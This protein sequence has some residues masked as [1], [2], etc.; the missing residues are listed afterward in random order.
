MKIA[1]ILAREILDSRGN[2]TVEVALT[3]E[4][5]W[6]LNAEGVGRTATAVLGRASVPSG[7]STGAHEA[8]ELRDDEARYGGLGVTRAVGNVNNEIKNTLLGNEYDQSTLDETLIRLDGTPNKSRLGANAILG[9]SLA[10]AHAQAKAFKYLY[11]YFAD[12][13]D[14]ETISLPLPLMNVLNGGKQATNSLDFQEYMIVPVG[15][16]SFHEALRYGAETFHALKKILEQKNLSTLVGDEGGFAPTLNSNEEGI[17]L[18]ME[19][20]DKAGYSA[21]QDIAIAIDSAASGWLSGDKYELPKDGK[22]LTAEEL[23]NLYEE[24]TKK[25]PLISIEDG[26]AEDDW[27]NWKIL[28]ERL[29]EKIQI[30]GDDLFVTNVKRLRQGIDEKV[31]NAILIKPNQIGTITETI[32]AIK[33]AK[34]AGYKTIVSHRSGETED[35]TIADL[36]VGLAA[37]QI[38]TGSLSRSERLAKYNQLWRIEEELGSK[39]VFSGGRA[40]TKN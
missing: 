15:A 25:Y 11:Q 36:S 30:V 20:I 13:S 24:W 8:L 4:D 5:S 39:A 33:L 29:G 6:G 27:A 32:E 12:I 10:F 18:L 26:L 9:V 1:N 19:A 38:K 21:G 35:T 7:A 31:A 37:G 16:G 40:L 34:F 23:I 3:L 28:T 2:P 14:T 22:T 17:Q